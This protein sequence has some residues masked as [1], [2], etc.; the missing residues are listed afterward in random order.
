M[1]R[2]IRQ[3]LSALRT[4][5]VCDYCNGTLRDPHELQALD[6]VTAVDGTVYKICGVCVH[7]PG[8]GYCLECDLVLPDKAFNDPDGDETCKHCAHE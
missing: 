1:S 8:F 3:Q 4:V 6:T 2:T 7:Q 5:D